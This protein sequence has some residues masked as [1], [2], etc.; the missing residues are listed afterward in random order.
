MLVSDNGASGEE[1]PN[2]SLNENKFMNQIPDDIETNLAMIDELG[3][4]KTY[5]H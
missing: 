2:G 1:G 4:P 3:S 5:N